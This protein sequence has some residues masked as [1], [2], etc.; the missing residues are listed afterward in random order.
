M[1]RLPKKS[2][3]TPPTAVAGIAFVVVLFVGEAALGGNHPAPTDAAATIARFYHDHRAGALASGYIQALALILLIYFSAIVCEWLWEAGQPRL[4]VT[5]FAGAVLTAATFLVYLF[6]QSALAYGIAADSNADI[7][8][9][10]YQLRFIAET[11]VSFPAAI[12]VGAASVAAV[13]IRTLPRWHAWG[14]CLIALSLLVAGADVARNGLFAP[15]GDLA[16][17]TLFFLLPVWVVSTG[18]LLA[19]RTSCDRPLA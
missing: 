6:V 5:A 14:G 15:E 3:T 11:F 1:S 10:L 18:V 13:R 8:K 17:L 4:A 2:R 19:R 9:A 16:F 7:T 12:L